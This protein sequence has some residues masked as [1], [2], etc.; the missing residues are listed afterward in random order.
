MSSASL[1]GLAGLVG[2]YFAGN[3]ILFLANVLGI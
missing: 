3:N 1:Q 2:R